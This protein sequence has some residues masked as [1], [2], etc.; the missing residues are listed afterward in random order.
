MRPIIQTKSTFY[1][2]MYKLNSPTVGIVNESDKWVAVAIPAGAVVDVIGENMAQGSVDVRC[3]DQW[4]TS[5]KSIWIGAGN[6]SSRPAQ[7]RC[8]VGQFSPLT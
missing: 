4:S 3:N 5:S 6:A 1:F 2:T 7:P 8:P